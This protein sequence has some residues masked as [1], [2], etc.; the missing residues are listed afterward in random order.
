MAWKGLRLTIDGRNALS[1]AQTGKTLIFDR[2]DIGDGPEPNNYNT[3]RTLVNK[4]FSIKFSDVK[5][6]DDGCILIADFPKQSY[7]FFF[8]EM[9]VIVRTDSGELLYLYDN[10]G[11]DAEHIIVSSGAEWREKRVRLHLKFSDVASIQITGSSV[12]YATFNELQELKDLKA[13]KKVTDNILEIKLVHLRWTNWMQVGEFW[14]QEVNVT[15]ITNKSNPVLVKHVDYS[16]TVEKL[17]IYNKNYS[18]IAEGAAETKDG[19]VVF[20]TFKKPTQDIMV[21]L[22]GV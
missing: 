3:Q 7:D 16:T 4:L 22:K 8:R 17:K 20:K 11:D 21:G 19:S 2:L 15:G 1:D 5:K 13:D 18:R 6:V 9:A 10:C 14:Q 12:L